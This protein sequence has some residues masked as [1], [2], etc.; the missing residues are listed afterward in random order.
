MR[1]CIVK[2]LFDL[3]FVPQILRKEIFV[4]Q[5][6]AIGIYLAVENMENK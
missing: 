2:S 5:F 6:A 4:V 3:K 1:V